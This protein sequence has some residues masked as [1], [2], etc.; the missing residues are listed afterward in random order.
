VGRD[1]DDAHRSNSIEIGCDG[2]SVAVYTLVVYTLNV[3]QLSL[4][5]TIINHAPST[6]NIQ[7]TK[8]QTLNPKP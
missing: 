1:H 6:Y 3:L 5:N 4:Y 8:P 7:E 2:F